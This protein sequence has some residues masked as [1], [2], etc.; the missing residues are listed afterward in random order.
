V[1]DRDKWKETE[2]PQPLVEQPQQSALV[3]GSLS[4]EIVLLNPI[5]PIKRFGTP[6]L[7]DL[8]SEQSCEVR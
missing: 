7:T 4:V 5:A 2:E 6:D 3:S 1:I 8:I